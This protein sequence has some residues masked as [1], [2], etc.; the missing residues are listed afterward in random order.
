MLSLFFVGCPRPLSQTSPPE[1]ASRHSIALVSVL[2]GS[3]QKGWRDGTREKALFSRPTGIVLDRAGNLFIAD[4]NNHAIRKIDRFGLVTTIAGRG[5][6][7]FADGIGRAAMFH[8]PDTVTV[9]GLGNLYVADADNF[10]IRKIT[11]DGVVTTVA[12]SG[13]AGDTEGRGTRAQFVYPTGVAVD[14]EGIIY[15]ADRGAHRIK[16]VTPGGDVR[17]LAGSGKPGFRDGPGYL[18]QFHDPITLV[19]DDFG[20]VYVADSGS[21]TIRRID[22]K[23]FVTTVAGSGISGYQDGIGKKVQFHW[24]TGLAIDRR[25]DLYVSDSEN[26]RIRKIV[27]PQ[28]RTTTLAGRGNPGYVDGL[29]FRAVFHFPTGIAVDALGNVFVADSAN[30]VI[31]HISSH[32]LRS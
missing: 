31:R 19:V 21:H 29:S 23:G 30:N 32:L 11:P 26:H 18:A 17:V 1:P 20:Q 4:H 15:V 2:A 16:I 8:G 5:T 22:R 9:D 13:T 28:G 25:G 3:G 6:P 10:R 12:G 24:P 7:G 14:R 27:L